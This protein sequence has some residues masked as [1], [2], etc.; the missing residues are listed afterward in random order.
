MYNLKPK[1]F[2]FESVQG[3]SKKQLDEHYKLY[4]GYV[5][6]L[7]EIWNTPYTPDDYTDSNPTYSKMRS[8]KLG[9]T[10]SL[11]G[12]KLHNLYFE[13]IT[14]GNNIPYGPIFNAI[15]N[16]FFTYDNFISYLT[17]VG[18]SM[19]GWAVLTLDLL[20]NSLHIIGSD[21][22]DNGSV[23]LSCPI[24]IMDIYEHAYFMDFGINRKKYISTFIDNINWN[25]LNER[26]EKYI[27]PLKS[28]D[29]ASKTI[30]RS[31]YYHYPY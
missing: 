15:I 28:M 19:R 13:N 25:I 16:Q 21:S 1:I 2:N 5:S 27:S 8:L 14:G 18:L 11:N 24:L 22:H 7:N 3:I 23:W 31:R 4:T 10:Y 30:N 29:M 9:E 26:F 12:I 17:N 6:K 20:D